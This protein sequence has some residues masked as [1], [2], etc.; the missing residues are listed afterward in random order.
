MLG[1]LFQ[2]ADYTVERLKELKYLSARRYVIFACYRGMKY[3]LPNDYEFETLRKVAA[4]LWE[5]D[6]PKPKAAA[7][8]VVQ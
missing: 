1:G 6:H 7:C 4:T 5:V 2:R 8:C 3:M